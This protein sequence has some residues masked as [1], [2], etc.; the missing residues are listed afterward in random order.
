MDASTSAGKLLLSLK[1]Q[2]RSKGL[3]Y[4]DVAARLKV[5]EGTVK[6]YFSGKGVTINVLEKLAQT[7]DLDL[8][9]LAVLA[10][11]QNPTV[12]RLTKA[13]QAALKRSKISTTVLYYLSIGFTPA[14][15]SREFDLAEQMDT[16]LAR[17]Q[18]WGMIRRLSANNVKML[19]E[20]RSGGSSDDDVREGRV[21]MVRRFLAEIDLRDDRCEWECFY[22]RLSTAAAARLQEIIKRFASDVR[23]LTKSGIDLPPEET[24]WYRL[25]VGAEPASRKNIFR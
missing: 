13:Q 12:P 19:V 25:F 8:L 1:Q 24:Q 6:R 15:L 23:A 2:L 21:N 9:S 7:V 18:D 11:Q 22:A 5:S 10:Q 17:L 4:R 14:Q 20:P 3:H 16:I